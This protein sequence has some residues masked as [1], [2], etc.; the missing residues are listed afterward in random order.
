[1]AWN[2]LS[3]TVKLLALLGRTRPEVY[4][5]F[6][7][8]DPGVLNRFDAVALN[9]QP[10]PPGRELVAGA[11]VMARRIAQIAVQ[12]EVRGEESPAWVSEIIDD[13]CGTMWPRKWPWPGPGPRPDEGPFPEPWRLNEAQV[14]GAVVFAS[15]AASLGEGRL[16]DALG[17]GAEQL[18]DAATQQM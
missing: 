5:A 11:V 2:E 14:A 1:M 9:P 17:K 6:P 18:V 12:A 10:I 16:R 8:H 15:L 13:W 3:Q 7:P 4:D